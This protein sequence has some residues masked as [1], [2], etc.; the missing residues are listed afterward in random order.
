MATTTAPRV[1]RVPGFREVNLPERIARIPGWAATGGLLVILVAASAFIRTRYLSGQ[2][3][4]DEAITTGIS[5]HSLSAI[6]GILRHDG[7]PPLFYLLL[8]FWIRLFGNSEAAT[9]TLPL[10]FGLLCIP[11]GMWAGSSLFGRRAGWYAGVLF[12]F[13]TFLTEYATETRMYELMGLLGILGTAAF[14]HGFVYRRRKYVVMFGVVEALMLYTHAW[15]LFFGAGTAI[16]LIP[17]VLATPRAERRP[18]IKDAVMA[19]AGA[20]ILFLPWLPNF[21][22]QATHTGAPWAPPPRFGA[23]VLIS[24]DLLGGDRITVAL[25]FSAVLGFAPLFTK[26]F[27]GTRETTAMWTLIALPIATLGLAWIASQ[28]T[29]A[30][31]SRYFAPALAAIL[32]FAAWG[33]A[34]S[35]IVG[36]IAIFLSVIFVLHISNYTPQYKS[37]V[38]EVGGVMSSHVHPGDLVVVAQPEQVPLAYYYLP[39]GLKFASPLGRVSDPTY[40]NWVYALRRLRSANPAATLDPLLASL[41]P[42]QQL[43][44]VRPLTEGAQ[45]WKASWTELVRRRAAQ[46]G[47]IIAGDKSLK[48]VAAANPLNYRGACCVADSATLWKKL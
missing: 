35:G 3:W 9:H 45:N 30:F 13:S 34:R 16:A 47:A 44:Y 1:P 5:S 18:L 7:S 32:L 14:I 46:W 15:G 4:M 6:P 41:K 28:I 17:T 12:A 43:L 25:L 23:P 39:G 11:A 33:A 21:I 26:R 36:L 29:P 31:V 10:L 27:R 42:G 38:R 22:Y 40:M 37:D 8:H 19:Y 20:V 48:E 24:R 2:F